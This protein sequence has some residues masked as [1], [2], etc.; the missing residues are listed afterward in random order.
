M[1]GSS[2]SIMTIDVLFEG[3]YSRILAHGTGSTTV[4]SFVWACVMIGSIL[5]A[6]LVG[7]IGDDGNIT[8]AFL[9]CVPVFLQLLYPLWKNVDLSLPGDRIEPTYHTERL[10]KTPPPS[11]PTFR[12]WSLCVL[13]CV[14]TGILLLALFVAESQPWAVVGVAAAVCIFLH[15][16]AFGVY[17]NHRTL[18]I[19]NLYMFLCEA[20]Y[21]DINCVSDY[22]YM[23]APDCVPNG[24]HFD[25]I[26][27]TTTAC[28]L[29]G[30]IGVCMAYLYA[31]VFSAWSFR[32]TI[33]FA[34]VF[35]CTST[36]TDV[37][38][39]QRWH[40]YIGLGDKA[41]FILGDAIVSP[42]ASMLVLLP[43]VVLTSKLVTRGQ[44]STTYAILAGFQNLG[45][46]MARIAGVAHTHSQFRDPNRSPYL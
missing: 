42:A 31:R 27:Y 24:P 38:V 34:A 6:I 37:M 28:V 30:I 44:E 17:R 43:M 33:V 41:A 5:G 10:L 22:W 39:A 46:T 23:A 15:G 20:L 26:I 7:P 36:F 1:G 12:D 11:G 18:W 45:Q 32:S 4:V 40:L 14:G 3:A 35:R 25:L 16:W 2:I 13:M 19:I 21:I 29:G 9:L 8:I